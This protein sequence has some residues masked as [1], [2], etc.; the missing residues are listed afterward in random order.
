MDYTF[1]KSLVLSKQTEI[2][3]LFLKG[4]R[5]KNSVFTILYREIPLIE[6]PFQVLVS[7]PKRKMKKAVHRNYIK[8][9]IR[10]VVRKSKT[11]FEQKEIAG[12]SSLLYG[13]VYNSEKKLEHVEIEKHLLQLL[14]K[15]QNPK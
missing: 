12:Q 5:V 9:C 13:I 15:I 10:E 8:R 14:Q 4:K 1:D 11:L 3:A 7:V 2:D 6:A